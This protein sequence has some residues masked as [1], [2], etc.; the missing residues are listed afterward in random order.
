V[1]KFGVV[2]CS[3]LV[4]LSIIAGVCMVV[5]AANYGSVKELVSDVLQAIDMIKSRKESQSDG[6]TAK[7]HRPSQ[8]HR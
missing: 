6:K 8:S 1:T 2:V 3:I 7:S 4:V 5:I